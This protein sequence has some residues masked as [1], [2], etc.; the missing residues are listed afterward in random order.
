MLTTAVDVEIYTQDN[1]SN[2]NSVAT[3]GEGIA[4]IIDYGAD[5]TGVA[6]STNATQAAINYLEANGGG[7]VY[8]PPGKYKITETLL[9]TWPDATGNPQAM[10]RVVLRGAG[11][12][13]TTFLDYRPG[14]PS[15]GMVSYDMSSYAD[16]S[17]RYL[18]SWVGGFSIH[19]MVNQTTISTGPYTITPG[20]GIGLYLA[21]MVSGEF[22]DLEIQGHNIAL[23][24]L[25]CLGNAY[26]D[27]SFTLAD[28]GMYLSSASLPPGNTTPPNAV[29]INH[30]T[31]NI[32]KTAGLDIVHG[33]V[34]ISGCSFSFDGI[35]GTSAGAIRFTA[36]TIIN[37]GLTVDTCMFESNSGLADIYVDALTAAAKTAVQVSNCTFVRNLGTAAVTPNS[38]NNI[39]I[40]SSAT[41]YVDLTVISCGFGQFNTPSASTMFIGYTGAGAANTRAVITGNAFNN[42][43]ESPISG[44]AAAS[45]LVIG[46]TQ[47]QNT[48]GTYYGY[49][50]QSTDVI[51]STTYGTLD[52][53]DVGKFHEGFGVL[54][55]TNNA[56]YLGYTTYRWA[57]ASI[58]VVLFGATGD[59]GLYSG[60][61]SPEG[62]LAA[63]VG[64]IYTNLSGGASTTLYVK[65]S[66]AATSSGWTAK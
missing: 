36:D 7:V 63:A 21:N 3:A 37:K 58:S 54:P 49:I 33:G 41:S 6:D 19:R 23:K 30:C 17:Y 34:G 25:N 31:M 55:N 8:A 1:I 66:G 9:F 20:T 42:T 46:R 62:V 5:L 35:G 50:N 16:N 14:S 13:I 11:S 38:T 43:T 56:R 51:G 60:T 18:Y 29:E 64:S 32:C 57:A 15:G 2:T 65:T 27:S 39:Q 44:G 24:A 52:I 47:W 4:N 45:Q 28:I 26:N 40:A 48:A 53:N 22:R 61:G 59:A 10:G 12:G